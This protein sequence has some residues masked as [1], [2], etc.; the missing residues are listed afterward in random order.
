MATPPIRSTNQVT[1]LPAQLDF[2]R[3]TALQSR[4]PSARVGDHFER[5][6]PLES[7][8]TSH[9]QFF[10]FDE[11]FGR[12]VL[13]YQLQHFGINDLPKLY[14]SYLLFRSTSLDG[15]PRVDLEAL[16]ANGQAIVTLPLGSSLPEILHTLRNTLL[17]SLWG[18]GPTCHGYLKLANGNSA[19]I[20]DESVSA[21][22]L[23]IQDSALAYPEE[24]QER[25]NLRTFADLQ[26]ILDF[27]TRFW[28]SVDGQHEDYILLPDGR[29]QVTRADALSL[30]RHDGTESL[31]LPGFLNHVLNLELPH[32]KARPEPPAKIGGLL[33]RNG[34]GLLRA[35][36]VQPAQIPELTSSAR[37]IKSSLPRASM[38]QVSTKRRVYSVWPV[39]ARQ[40]FVPRAPGR[41]TLVWRSHPRSI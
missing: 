32:I 19:L 39:P 10:G 2:F 3:K 5:V 16:Q 34:H 14:P 6:V 35:H 30:L 15:F 9:G 41:N 31:I 25:I 27:F 24:L 13:Q 1:A 11:A 38:T 21:I 20:M 29:L 12:W 26:A 18:L 22:S 40:S 4:D 37:V 8:W 23:R 33:R 36:P 17:L 7:A 28:V